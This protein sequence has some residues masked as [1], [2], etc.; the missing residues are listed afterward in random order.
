MSS[1]QPREE[2]HSRRSSAPAPAR[3]G[4]RY[5]AGP[6]GLVDLEGRFWS[7]EISVPGSVSA[8]VLAGGSGSRLRSGATEELRSTPKP[9]VT[10]DAGEHLNTPMIGVVLKSLLDN[11][12]SRAAVVTS[13]VPSAGADQ[14]ESFVFDGFG[15]APGLR[16]FR[17]A[18][19]TGTGGAVFAALR[20]MCTQYVVVMMADTLLP[21]ARVQAAVREHV[22]H[23]ADVTWCVTSVQ[24]RDMP[25]PS[26]LVIDPVTRRFL[27]AWEERRYPSSVAKDRSGVRVS[28]AGAVVVTAQRFRQ[29][30]IAFV[31]DTPTASVDLHRALIPSLAEEPGYTVLGYDLKVPVH[32]LGTP[33]RLFRHGRRP[34][35]TQPRPPLLTERPKGTSP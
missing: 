13:S 30:F 26:A 5:G 9:L 4:S 27:W 15:D 1:V 32:D 34:T 20:W 14:V 19:Q 29:A 16:V 3:P 17:E 25:H 33:E 24:T 7:E 22:Q 6:D 12:F 10:V 31:S 35:R 28:S 18:N 8:L 23:A 2:A 11:G 21:P